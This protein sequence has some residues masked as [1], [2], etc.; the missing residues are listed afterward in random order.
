MHMSCNE[1]IVRVSSKKISQ[2]FETLKSRRP[3]PINL[4]YFD[5]KT[6]ITVEKR[7][8]DSEF[9]SDFLLL[10]LYELLLRSQNK[11]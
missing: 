2:E 4:R 6:Y 11:V 10:S 9:I 5:F 8:D 3:F 1:R 7:E